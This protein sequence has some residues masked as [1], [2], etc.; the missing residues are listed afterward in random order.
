MNS[1]VCFRQPEDADTIICVALVTSV[2]TS[3]MLTGLLVQILSPFNAICLFIFLFRL[4]LFPL[5]HSWL[6]HYAT[7]Q[8]FAGS[9][10]DEVTGFLN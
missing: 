1:F 4:C 6:T 2:M 3:R 8:K 5:Y 10:P 9:S 7:S